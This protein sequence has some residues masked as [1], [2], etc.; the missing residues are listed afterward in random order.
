MRF[1]NNNKLSRT[2]TNSNNSYSYSSN[3]GNNG[4]NMNNNNMR[5]SPLTKIPLQISSRETSGSTSAVVKLPTTVAVPST[6]SSSVTSSRPKRA[7]SSGSSISSFHSQPTSVC[8]QRL[9]PPPYRICELT[10]DTTTTSSSSFLESPRTLMEEDMMEEVIVEEDDEGEEK[11]K[12]V[13][14]VCVNDHEREHFLSWVRTW[15]C[16]PAVKASNTNM[17][18]INPR[19]FGSCGEYSYFG[20]LG[21]NA[22]TISK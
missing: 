21:T 20:P 4:N 7:S 9:E 5:T 8:D 17:K 14:E 12:D 2:A 19:F 3:N 18:S 22:T 16:R 11:T 6:S 10:D 13:I 1:N 15:A